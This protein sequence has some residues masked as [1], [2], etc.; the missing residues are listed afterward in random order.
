MTDVNNCLE[1]HCKGP[2][3]A[4]ND[5]FNFFVLLQSNMAA[6]CDMDWHRQ[7]QQRGLCNAI[8]DF[9]MFNFM[10][11]LLEIGMPLAHN[12][13]Q[14]SASERCKNYK[15]LVLDSVE[16]ETNKNECVG[17]ILL[18]SYQNLIAYTLAVNSNA[19]FIWKCPDVYEI[20]PI[21]SFHKFCFYL[22]V[23]KFDQLIIVNILKG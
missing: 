18:S 9:D 4:Q 10:G 8:L 5:V 6:V 3:M 7:R 15:K 14:L 11:T 12:F 16:E 20:V 21:V 23:S 17:P 19:S 22:S 13:T 1:E 2:S